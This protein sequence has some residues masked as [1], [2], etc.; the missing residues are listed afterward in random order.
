[1]TTCPDC[2]GKGKIVCPHCDS[3]HECPRCQ[4]FG[5][6]FPEEPLAKREDKEPTNVSDET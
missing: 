5:G 2:K 6:Y 1:M 3:L 4:G